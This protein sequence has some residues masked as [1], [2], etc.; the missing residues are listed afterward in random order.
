MGVAQQGLPIILV[1]TTCQQQQKAERFCQYDPDHSPLEFCFFLQEYFY[2]QKN[3]N[4]TTNE[5]RFTF[6][7][8][9]RFAEFLLSVFHNTEGLVYN[10]ETNNIN[11]FCNKLWNKLWNEHSLD[12]Q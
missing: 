11:L 9:A 2:Q 8:N 1:A 12:K 3:P 7:N 4:P 10:R 6:Q 5:H